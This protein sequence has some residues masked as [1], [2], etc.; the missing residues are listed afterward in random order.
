MKQLSARQLVRSLIE[1]NKNVTLDELVDETGL[2][3]IIKANIGGHLIED[4]TVRYVWERTVC[5]IPTS[6]FR[7]TFN[8][9]LERHLKC[10]R[11]G[12]EYIE[13]L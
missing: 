2:S 12:G 3:N 7:Q 11:V 13:K 8:K 1:D 9:W 4:E 6:E 5:T 10:L